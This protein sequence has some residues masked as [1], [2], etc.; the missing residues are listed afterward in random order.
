MTVIQDIASV[1]LVTESFS[2]ARRFNP[3]PSG[4]CWVRRGP[5][6]SPGQTPR[7]YPANAGLLLFAVS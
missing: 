4:G 1:R 3:P 2:P 7:Q 5:P 6:S